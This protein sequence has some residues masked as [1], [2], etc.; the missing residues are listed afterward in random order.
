[1]SHHRNPKSLLTPAMHSVLDRMAR[2][3][4]P[5]LHALSPDQA[6]R[7]PQPQQQQRHAARLGHYKAWHVAHAAKARNSDLSSMSS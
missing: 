4:H 2:A 1:M 6:Q 3:G 7:Q 5:P